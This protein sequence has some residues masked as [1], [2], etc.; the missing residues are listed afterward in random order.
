MREEINIFQEMICWT[1]VKRPTY[2]QVMRINFLSLQKKR[3]QGRVCRHRARVMVCSNKEADHEE[4]KFPGRTL[5]RGKI[6]FVLVHSTSVV[7]EA[8][9][10]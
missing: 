7:I 3:D 5:L 4:E 2:E 10:F 9:S 1:V 6:N 8:F